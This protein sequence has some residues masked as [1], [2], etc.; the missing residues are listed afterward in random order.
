MRVP[1]FYA[2]VEQAERR[3]AGEPLIVGGDPRKGACV[4]SA[5]V[6][7][8]ALGIQEETPVE[9]ALRI[10]PTLR[11]APTRMRVYREAAAA[12]RALLRERVERME[13]SGLDGVYLESPPA[14]EPLAFVADACV[15]VKAELGLD[16]VAGL[17]P[18]RFVAYLA[19]QHP[20]EG[21]LRV[22]SKEEALEFLGPF[23]VAELWGLG[24]ASA[25]KLAQAGIVQIVDLQKRKLSELA[26]IVGRRNAVT[27]LE[28]ATARDLSRLRPAPATK[29]LS[30]EQTLDEAT[31]ETRVLSERLAE[32]ARC[33]EAMLER[34]RQAARTVCLGLTYTEGERCTRTHTLARA[35]TSHQELASLAV[36]LLARTDAEQRGVRKLSLKVSNLGR[37]EAIDDPRQLRLF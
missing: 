25:E 37:R 16:V 24:P 35:L 20:T 21:G 2:A 12:L 32:L 31:R 28:L 8:R 17:G 3:C 36:E 18:T 23:P 13:P 34:E 26:T 19:A 1:S 10:C 15:R 27:F 33:V 14:A 22:V 30:R 29:S 11:R 7:A 6:E 9:E 4:L 5:S